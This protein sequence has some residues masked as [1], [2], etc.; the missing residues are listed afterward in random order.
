MRGAA[1]R[2]DAA[3]RAVA[4]RTSSRVAPAVLASLAGPVFT[5]VAYYGGAIAAFLVG[6]YS[7]RIFAPFWP[8]NT[9]LFAA[10]LLAPV[11]RW[12]LYLAVVAPAHVLAEMWVAMPPA[13]M[14][15]AYL[16]NCLFAIPAAYLLRRFGPPWFGSVRS[17]VAYI[18]IAA[19]IVPA[20]AALGGG[21]V[22]IV[23]GAPAS[24]YAAY[25]ATWF[26]GNA[27]AALTLGPAILTWFET[28]ADRPLSTPRAIE[29]VLLG[30]CL[31]AVSVAGFRLAAEAAGSGLAPVLLF[32]PLPVML[33]MA[34]RFGARGASSGV[35]VFA[36]IAIANAV[37]G[38]SVFVAGSVEG[39]VIALQLFLA[40]VALPKLFI[41]SAIDQ[42]RHAEGALKRLTLAQS[43]AEEEER[44]RI[45]RALHEGT[46]QNLSA[47]AMFTGTSPAAHGP[48]PRSGDL[49][50]RAIV[51]IRRLSSQLHPPL[52][53]G[54]GLAPALLDL[55][56][57]RSAGGL[58]VELSIESEGRDLSSEARLLLFRLVDKTLDAA[59]EASDGAAVEI[60]F[61]QDRDG[62]RAYEMV[63]ERDLAR[64]TAGAFQGEPSDLVRIEE[65]L[66]A[67]GGSLTSGRRG[68][69]MVIRATVPT[70]R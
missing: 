53:D 44:R 14:L 58:G 54:P 31:V 34:Y 42:L 4:D 45:A 39:T 66:R 20:L 16:T 70:S 65:R 18:V 50:R 46:A 3:A 6:T 28:T 11:R 15:V 38:P 1:D 27:L 8:P 63:I 49:I 67:I 29:A 47:A 32:L 2:P 10:L 68:G 23:G 51:D 37:G 25:A 26:A 22:P 59:E 69:R 13:Q 48:E 9:I 61:G 7:D 19:G 21:L 30:G 33:W 52:L 60:A 56:R 35:L 12:P 62:D 55:V 24:G 43:R 17:L 5:A 36:T 64:S 41:G 57:E 40:A